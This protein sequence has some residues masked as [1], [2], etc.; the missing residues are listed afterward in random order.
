AA[1]DAEQKKYNV[2]KSTTFTVLQLQA[3]LTTAKSQE[4]RAL[5][6]YNESLASLALQE[7]TTLERYQIDLKISPDEN[8]SLSVK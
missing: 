2:G 6:D 7:G 1:L 5:A 8:S 4:I 3:S